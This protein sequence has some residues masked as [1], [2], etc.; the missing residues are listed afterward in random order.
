MKVT[1]RQVINDLKKISSPVRAKNLARFFKTGPGQYGEGDV[2]WG[3]TVPDIRQVA[4]KYLALSLP[5]IKKLLQNKVHECRFVGLL[6]LVDQFK[7]GQ[8]QQ[9]KILYDFYLANSSCV[10]S[11]DLV[12]LSAWVIVGGYLIDHPNKIK[13]LQKLVKSKILWQRRIAV[14]AGG[15]FIRHGRF[16]ITLDLAKKLLTDPH[17]LMH[18]AVG[19]MLREVGKKDQKVLEKF[20]DEYATKLPRTA[21]RYAIERLPENKR[22]FYLKK[23]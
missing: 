6:I 11:W 19:W 3:L 10:N 15:A 17:D 5:E 20:L 4:K 22:L 8:E 12:D 21:L 23:I 9:R 13:L 1:T 14:L 18:K 2:F 7:K 16:D